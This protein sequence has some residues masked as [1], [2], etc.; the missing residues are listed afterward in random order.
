LTTFTSGEPFSGIIVAV[1]GSGPHKSVLLR[2]H[3]TRVGT[4]MSIKIHSPLVQSMEI[5][6]RGTKRRKRARLYYLRQPKHDVGTVQGI[7]DQ[8]LRER[9]ALAGK[10]TASRTQGSARKKR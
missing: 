9:R 6:K 4:E 8:Y 1:K 2:N 3:L 7:V 10:R 5:A